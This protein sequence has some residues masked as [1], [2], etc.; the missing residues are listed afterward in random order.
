[1]DVGFDA[2][3]GLITFPLF[4][5]NGGLLG[6]AR[7]APEDGAKYYLSGTFKHIKDEGYQAIPVNRGSCLWGWWEQREKIASGAPIVVVEGYVDQLKLL[8]YGMCA[9]AKL[10]RRLTDAQKALLLSVPNKLVH[11]PDFDTDGLK[12]GSQDVVDLMSRPDTWV[13]QHPLGLKDAGDAPRLV[14]QSAVRMA[15]TPFGFLER[16]PAL[17]VSCPFKT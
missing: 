10:G 1:M 17:L 9:V 8:S 12:S 11:W 16:L 14:A 15:T 13:V 2:R 3:L 6:I 5:A 7:R 4:D